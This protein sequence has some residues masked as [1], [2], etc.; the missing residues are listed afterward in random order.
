M[1]I[2]WYGEYK[3]NGT[4]DLKIIPISYVFFGC[5]FCKNVLKWVCP[6]FLSSIV[7]H[8]QCSST[9]KRK[10]K[11]KTHWNF[12]HNQQKTALHYTVSLHWSSQ[13]NKMDVCLSVVRKCFS[14]VKNWDSE[15]I[16]FNH[17][18]HRQ[19]GNHVACGWCM[20]LPLYWYIPLLVEIVKWEV[21]YNLQHI[22][23]CLMDTSNNCCIS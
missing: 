5:L 17:P 23:C 15:D 7:S 18:L 10:E 4:F 2:C 22:L 19:L 13:S 3:N 9:V 20:A 14:E 6:Y 1:S 8:N 11:C 12:Q 21:G 16:S